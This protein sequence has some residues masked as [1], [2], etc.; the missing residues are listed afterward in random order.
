MRTRITLNRLIRCISSRQFLLPLGLVAFGMVAIAVLASVNP[1]GTAQLLE[2]DG[3]V[4]INTLGNDD[5]NLLNGSGGPNPTG[6]A[7]H[8]VARAFIS[9]P[10]SPEIFTTGGSKDPLDISRWRWTSGS[11]PDKDLLTNGYAAAYVTG[12]NNS[13][14]PA[15]QLLLYFGADRFAQNGDSNIGVWFFQQ[16][17]APITSGPLTGQFSGLHTNGDLLIVSAFTKGGGTST[18]TVYAWDSACTGPTFVSPPV[19]QTCA[20]NNLFTLSAGSSAEAFAIVNDADLSGANVPSWPYTPKSGSP[21]TI[22]AGGFYEAGINVSEL[23][24]G[25]SIPVPCFTSFLEETRSSQ[26]TSAVLKDFI[27]GSFPL[28]GLHITKACGTGNQAPK[29]INNGTAIQ[30]TFTGTVHNT[31]IGTLSNVSVADT[32]PDGTA[33]SPILSS[34]TLAPNGQA[35]DTAT[36][37]DTFTATKSNVA[38]P[39]SVMNSATASST[40]SSTTVNSDNTATA[41][42]SL[43]VSATLSV[44]KH[45]VAPGPNLSCT[46][47]GCVVQVPFRGHVCNTGSV[48]LT[49]ITLADDPVALSPGITPNGFT[50]NPGQCTA[51]SG[52]PADPTGAYQ[53]TSANVSGNGSIPGRFFFADTLFVTAATAAIGSNPTPVGAPCPAGALACGAQSCPLCPL[54]ECTSVPLP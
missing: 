10:S 50:L 48:Q 41:T 51:D 38:N 40:F 2:L 9:G 5:W 27:G 42:C 4:V 43:S 26:S 14:T 54:N 34:T 3:N 1:F 37:T 8:S 21:G 19:A 30:Y 36:W 15:G 25:L 13:V 49:G 31:G 23:L 7:G 12:T 46:S 39:L 32:L 53:P 45:C 28:C 6:S 17:V 20:D 52:A 16:T 47:S 35:G 33:G 24:A 18:I 29:T 11:V 22:P 44:V